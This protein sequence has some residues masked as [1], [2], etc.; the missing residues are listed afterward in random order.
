[1]ADEPLQFRQQ[2]NGPVE[3][4]WRL[5][6]SSK[7]RPILD[8]VSGAL[9]ALLNTV[10]QHKPKEPTV[11]ETVQAALAALLGAIGKDQRSGQL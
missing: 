5:L 2:I 7:G 11:L 1:M 4:I 3:T 8:A 9:G 10:G 6:T